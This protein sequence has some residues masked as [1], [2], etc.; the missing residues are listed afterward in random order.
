[1]YRF[2]Y[3]Y[4][5]SHISTCPVTIHALLHI[6]DSIRICRPVWCYWAFPMERYCNRLKPAIKSRRFPYASIDHFVLEDAQ[7]TQIKAVY[8][9]A[10]ELAL[11]PQQRGLPAG[12]YS[13][14][15][16][17]HWPFSSCFYLIFPTADPTCILLPPCVIVQHGAK[18]G[19][20]PLSTG[21]SNAIATALS[22]RF[23][24]PMSSVR[25][26]LQ[27]AD[28]E[29][30]GKVRRVDSEAGDTIHSSSLTQHAVDRRDATFVRV[31]DIFLLN[32]SLLIF[33]A[34]SM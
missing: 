7:L 27:K 30:W 34:F 10:D 32:L 4:D 29:E 18:T 15:N 20:L 22:T 8:G 12:V 14:H 9:M 3:Q 23:D 17:E 11:Q 24:I 6:A 13:D 19:N 31:S 26:Y 1:M 2:Y 33:R 5:A 28:I 16:C 25:K 21:L